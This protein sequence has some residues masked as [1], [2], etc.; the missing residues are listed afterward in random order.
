MSL[1]PLSKLEDL[2][3]DDPQNLQPI[4]R[5]DWQNNTENTLLL[6]LLHPFSSVKNLYL[7]EEF[8]PCIVSALK[9]LAESG[10]AEVL[11]TLQNIFLEEVWPSRPV[12]DAIGQFAASRQ[13][14]GHPIAVTHWER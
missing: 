3:I 6:E 1:P 5:S 13:A 10:T 7:V 9:E 2:Y 11:P 4:R 12:R 14:T 8:A